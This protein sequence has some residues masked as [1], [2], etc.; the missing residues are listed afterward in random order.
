MSRRST[1][2]RTA[3]ASVTPEKRRASPWVEASL[4]LT[5]FFFG[6]NFVAVKHVVESMPPILRSIRER[7]LLHLGYSLFSMI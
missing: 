6:T 1:R 3:S 5:V 4:L 7:F 2:I